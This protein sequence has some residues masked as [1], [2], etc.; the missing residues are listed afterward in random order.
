MS[1][2]VYIA[3]PYSSPTRSERLAN[4]ERAIEAGY[5]LMCAGYIA[6]VP[7]LSHFIEEYA[8]VTGMADN[9]TYDFWLKQDFAWLRECDA[10]LY[11]GPSHGANL[12]KAMAEEMGIQ[13]FT[14]VE[15]AI[16]ALEAVAV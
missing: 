2:K 11:L 13:V 5:K 14:S 15:D 8:L 12:E 3:G 4:T 1:I 10:L 9:R 16:N 7:H 6:F